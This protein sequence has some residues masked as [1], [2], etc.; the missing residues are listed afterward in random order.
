MFQNKNVK[1]LHLTPHLGGGVGTVVRSYLE[2]C[3]RNDLFSHS[4]LSLDTLNSESKSL[5]D[6]IG[7]SW[8][9]S[10]FDNYELI[11]SLVSGADIVLMHWWNQPLLQNLLMT[12]SLPLSRVI[13]WSHISGQPPP[14]NFS[15]F[16][17]QYPDRFIFTT[18]LSYY[19]PEV[20]ALERKAQSQIACIWSTAGVERLDRYFAKNEFGLRGRGIVGYAGNLDYS[21][22]SN[23]FFSISD[24][25]K[26]HVNEMV[27]IGPMTE[28]FKNDLMGYSDGSHIEATGY[29]SEDEKFSRIASFDIFGYPLARHHYGTCDQAIQEAMAFGLPVIVLNNPMESYMV[30]HGQTG[31]IAANS[32]EYVANV[33]MLLANPEL[34]L[35][36]GEN[37]RKFAKSEYSINKLFLSWKATFLDV[38][39]Y[40]KTEKA[41]LSRMLNK[42][43][44]PNDVFIASL[45]SYGGL[46]LAHKQLKKKQDIDMITAQIG[47]LKGLPN[48]SGP[49]KSTA[50]HYFQ[51]FKQ[52][53]WLSE[54]SKLTLV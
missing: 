7:I 20:Q 15:N 53:E 17:L 8:V 4:V 21:K 41:S 28:N 44:L 2:Y 49:T 29:I 16:I 23:D 11:D 25:L 33:K 6:G 14:N 10:A 47:C 19:S 36:L 31:L 43:L 38:L 46:F 27:V 30:K 51:Y 26:G 34:R 50:T 42:T 40:P 32:Y 39:S 18:P 22:I 45:E 1:V 9:E 13:V 12:H 5:L 48:W 24:R 3:S 52:D 35:S 54:W 37:A